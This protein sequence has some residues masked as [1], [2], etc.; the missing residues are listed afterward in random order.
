MILPLN[1]T[2]RRD[3]RLS[4]DEFF[5]FCQANPSLRIE[6]DETGQIIFEMPTGITTSITNS[7]LNGE[8]Y[9]WNRQY[10]LGFVT[11][12]NGGFTLPDNSVR[13]PDVAWI[14]RERW[15]SV[16]D[17]DKDKFAHICPDFVIELM[18]DTDE[19][20][21]LPAKMEKYL[22]NGVRLGWQ[23]DPFSQQTTVYRPEKAPQVIPFDETLSGEDVL[24]N[25]S[26]RLSD[27][28]NN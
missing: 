12:S 20:Y 13:A 2:L 17:A 24:P 27:L 16:P 4:D 11:D 6:R 23:I 10:K 28:A 26:L 19:K 7:A 15:A 5:A 14:S 21:T 22:Q 3:E 25:F 8:L 18:S 1:P 9:L